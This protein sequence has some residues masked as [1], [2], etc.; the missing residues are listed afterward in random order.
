MQKWIKLIRTYEQT[1]HQKSS[2]KKK[3]IRKFSKKLNRTMRK[4]N[5]VGQVSFSLWGLLG[6]WH[7]KYN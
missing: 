6:L 7:T 2:K 5:R 3:T 4:S 1:D